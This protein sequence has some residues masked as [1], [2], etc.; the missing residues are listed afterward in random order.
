MLF[1]SRSKISRVLSMNDYEIRLISLRHEKK[2]SIIELHRTMTLDPG[3]IIHGEIVKAEALQK[4]LEKFIPQ[5]Y[6][7]EHIHLLLPHRLFSFHQLAVP[8]EFRKGKVKKIVKR[9]LAHLQ[10]KPEWLSTHAYEPQL[11]QDN[12]MTALFF[13]CLAK[14]V[15]DG[16]RHVFDRMNIFLDEVR[17]D[18]SA[19]SHLIPQGKTG[20]IMVKQDGFHVIN[21]ENGIPAEGH[22]VELSVDDLIRSIMKYAPCDEHQARSILFQYGFQRTHKSESV[23]K[24]LVQSLSPLV[25]MLDRDADRHFVHVCFESQPI[26]GL[27]DFLI[28]HSKHTIHELD[29]VSRYLHSPDSMMIPFHRNEGY[30][31]QALIAQGLRHQK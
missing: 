19:F 1:R 13:E 3:I 2:R 22:F 8:D 17:S 10:E 5:S 18:L 25:D 14:S 11:I 21:F 28:K 24:H 23:Y 31:Y 6:K 27:I 15:F 4:I 16:Y 7:K 20:F 26:P 12:K 9:V 30:S 29:V